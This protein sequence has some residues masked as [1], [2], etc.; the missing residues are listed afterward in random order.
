MVEIKWQDPPAALTLHDS[1]VAALKNNP[2]RWALVAE[3]RSS[4]SSG[5]P[6]TKSGFETKV[7]RKNPGD[8]KP[9]YDVYARWPEDW[10]PAQ[11]KANEAAAKSP[12]PAA[13]PKA[14]AGKTTVEK[15]LATGTALVPPAA[16]APKQAPAPKP[17]ND[18]GLQSFLEA[19][20]A[21]GAAR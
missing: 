11:A 2:G 12:A 1:I 8:G 20:R 18:M 5:T 3:D 6:W 16:T 17:A 21:R 15:A 4:S 19:R 7:H 13:T 10:K 14:A 9:K